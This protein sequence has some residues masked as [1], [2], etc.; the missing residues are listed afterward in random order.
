MQRPGQRSLLESQSGQEQAGDAL[1]SGERPETAHVRPGMERG[2]HV[3]ILGRRV[4][5]GPLGTPGG[6]GNAS[7]VGGT[8]SGGTGTGTG[9]G[10]GSGGTDYSAFGGYKPKPPNKPAPTK[11][12]RPEP[13]SRFSSDPRYGAGL[14]GF[15]SLSCVEEAPAAEAEAPVDTEEPVE[16]E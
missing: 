1:G 2:R 5:S 6:D 3:A 7:A 9:S 12:A 16:G 15:P 11:R 4:R 14:Y 13:H 10:S 8:G